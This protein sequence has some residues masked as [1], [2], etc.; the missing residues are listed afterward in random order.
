MRACRFL[1]LLACCFM[2]PLLAGA[3]EIDPELTRILRHIPRTD[4]ELAALHERGTDQSCEPIDDGRPLEVAGFNEAV[5][6]RRSMGPN[7]SPRLT[8]LESSRRA[9]LSFGMDMTPDDQHQLPLLSG[10]KI[11]E[12]VDRTY[13]AVQVRVERDTPSGEPFLHFRP[14]AVQGDYANRHTTTPFTAMLRESV[15]QVRGL[16]LYLKPGQPATAENLRTLVALHR[17]LADDARQAELEAKGVT[18]REPHF[19]L[20][21]VRARVGGQSTE[22]QVTLH[23]FAT[24]EDR[25]RLRYLPAYRMPS[26]AAD[27]S[28]K[29]TIYFT[30]YGFANLYP[31]AKATR[32]IEISDQASFTMA[33]LDRYA[34]GQGW[35]GDALAN[36]TEVLDAI[37]DGRIR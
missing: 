2:S 10:G 21:C 14:T 12:Y 22:R 19:E 3:A 36:L 4:A 18:G 26:K 33:D 23:A 17:S 35:E 11:L 32:R 16:G 13:I 1:A 37:I 15:G 30:S 27:C 8:V 5:S 29:S 6:H 28:I 25:T 7:G 31:A 34:A 24:T 20:L 9:V